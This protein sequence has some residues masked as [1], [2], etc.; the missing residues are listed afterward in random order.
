MTAKGFLFH[1]FGFRISSLRPS[2]LLGLCE[3]DKEFGSI[4][5]LSRFLITKPLNENVLLPVQFK[6]YSSLIAY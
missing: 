6:V 1:L 3:T 5:F 2:S 4:Q